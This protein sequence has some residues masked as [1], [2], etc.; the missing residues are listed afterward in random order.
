[1]EAVRKE[2]ER[3]QKMKAALATKIE[4]SCAPVAVALGKLVANEHWTLVPDV[5]RSPAEA[6]VGSMLFR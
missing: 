6:R 2:R 4:T 3:A 5:V 1:M